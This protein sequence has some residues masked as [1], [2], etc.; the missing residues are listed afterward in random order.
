[1]IRVNQL[2]QTSLLLDFDLHRFSMLGWS[3]GGITALCAAIQQPKAIEKVFR[4]QNTIIAS[5]S[6]HGL[7][8]AHSPLKMFTITVTIVGLNIWSPLSLSSVTCHHSCFWY[9]WITTDAGCGVGQQC[10]PCTGRHWHDQTGSPNWL[11]YLNK[12]IFQMIKY[13]HYFNISHDQT[14][15]QNKLQI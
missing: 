4:V 2:L 13:V 8:K 15:F 9:F 7:N 6:Q 1:M 10:L 12:S 3:D 5:W 11:Q 14:G